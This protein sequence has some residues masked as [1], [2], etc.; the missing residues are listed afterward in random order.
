MIDFWKRI[1]EALESR[2]IPMAEVSRITGIP[3]STISNWIRYD[4]YPTVDN[5]AKIA[6]VLGTSIDWMMTGIEPYDE[7][8]EELDPPRIV[9]LFSSIRKLD[10][11]QLDLMEPFVDYMVKN[12]QPKQPSKK[13]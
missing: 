11:S 6:N 8:D 10:E 4:R 1:Q 3:C 5:A 13:K 2:K 7:Y 12:K 9:H